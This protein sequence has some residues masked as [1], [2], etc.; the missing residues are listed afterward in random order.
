LAQPES[1]CH[2]GFGSNAEQPLP[3]PDHAVSLQPRALLA[4]VSVVPPTPVTYCDDAGQLT[5]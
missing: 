3:A 5:P 1:F 4:D 2:A